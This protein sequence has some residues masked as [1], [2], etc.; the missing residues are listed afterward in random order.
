MYILCVYQEQIAK[1]RTSNGTQEIGLSLWV[2]GV[3]RSVKIQHKHHEMEHFSVS[4]MCDYHETALNIWVQLLN[5][6][7]DHILN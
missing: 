5:E 6:I 7:F 2:A 4:R 1:L 3:P